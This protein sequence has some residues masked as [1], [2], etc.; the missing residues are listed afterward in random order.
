MRSTLLI[1]IL[2]LMPALMAQGNPLE[3]TADEIIANALSMDDATSDTALD[4]I[5]LMSAE[6]ARRMGDLML[7]M[8]VRGAERLLGIMRGS[9]NENVIICAAIAL[10]SKHE[11]IRYAGIGVLTSASPKQVQRT[12]TKYLTKKRLAVLR[13]TLTT[14]E[15]LLPLCRDFVGTYQRSP[16][17]SM[18]IVM[19]TDHFFGA[20]GFHDLCYA[21]SELME[22]EP[23]KSEPE[24]VEKTEKPIVAKEEFLEKRTAA[25]ALLASIWL[26]PPAQEFGYDTTADHEK[27]RKAM[28]KLRECLAA[29]SVVTYDLSENV[30]GVGTRYGDYLLKELPTDFRKAGYIRLMYMAGGNA[31]LTEK[32]VKDATIRDLLN[33]SD[34]PLEGKEYSKF[35]D[36]YS[37]MRVRLRRGINRKFS[38]WWKNYRIETDNP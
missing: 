11:D 22:G 2:L 26:S 20:S 21:L 10:S 16:Y 18:A 13:E 8:E 7:E 17:Y 25:T 14:P 1:F 3:V 31:K 23:L 29:L 33:A 24:E 12:S 4:Q 19:L 37:S 34:V 27:R 6:T 35:Y 15:K 28:G 30:K 36:A 9:E 32:E 38:K 5:A